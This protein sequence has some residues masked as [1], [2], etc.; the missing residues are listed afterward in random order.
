MEKEKILK[1]LECNADIIEQYIED[2]TFGKGADM[3]VGNDPAGVP[4]II[5]NVGKSEVEDWLVKQ[6]KTVLG[7]IFMDEC[8]EPEL[9]FP[10]FSVEYVSGCPSK[11]YL[12]YSV[13]NQVEYDYSEAKEY[14][15]STCPPSVISSYCSDALVRLWNVH[16]AMGSE[17]VIVFEDFGE[18]AA[19]IQIVKEIADK[20]TIKETN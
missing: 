5:I 7:E 16:K 8:R 14:L 2:G 20:I 13:C 4:S 15:E 17:G 18:I 1:K 10:S 12:N 19:T 11:I 6:L 9:V 3:T